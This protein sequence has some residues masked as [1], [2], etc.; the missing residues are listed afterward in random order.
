MEIDWEGLY[1]ELKHQIDRIIDENLVVG[2]YLIGSGVKK[3]NHPE[4][5]REMRDVDILVVLEY[6]EPEREVIEDNG[7]LFDIS[8]L[9]ISFVYE[10]KDY[11]NSFLYAAWRKK[12]MLF[13]P[14]PGE[15]V[16][17]NSSFYKEPLTK[18]NGYFQTNSVLDKLKSDK[19]VSPAVGGFLIGDWLLIIEKKFKEWKE[20]AGIPKE[21]KELQLTFLMDSTA[22]D[23]ISL[24]FKFDGRWPVVKKKFIDE[25][26][27]YDR[28]I[29]DLYKVFI[30]ERNVEKKHQQFRLLVEASA[31]KFG[32]I[33]KTLVRSYF[34]PEL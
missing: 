23:V 12:H 20:S 21:F 16:G 14:K 2:I 9:S 28:E 25:L 19:V 3:L 26:L 4:E 5:F 7:I 27:N 24:L 13:E 33:R 15:M 11:E 34:P 10:Y 17:R 8:Y 32:G 30:K 6:G 31:K 22:Y 1:P 29:F 18:E